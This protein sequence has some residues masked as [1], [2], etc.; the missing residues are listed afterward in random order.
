M[1]ELSVKTR[2][3]TSRLSDMDRLRLF[4]F[5]CMLCDHAAIYFLQGFWYTA[6]R[7]I[8]RFAFPC[9]AF[10]LVYGASVTSNL[11]RYR[12]R[13]FWL[14][15]VSQVPYALLTG[16]L[17]TLNVC[18]LFYLFLAYRSRKYGRIAVFVFLCLIFGLVPEYGPAGFLMLVFL[19]LAVRKRKW[20]FYLTSAAFAAFLSLHQGL[21]ATIPFFFFT[22][23]RHSGRV[24]SRKVIY[25]FYPVHLMVL[26][27]LFLFTG[28]DIYG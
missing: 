20:S 16:Y 17:W 14:A 23:I 28:G 3:Q 18:F 15:L 7:W 8:G 6:F 24:L 12:K 2:R 22:K 1:N 10:G 5:A 19:D 21:L 9:F 4:A 27:L 11:N 26:F 25:G 13:V